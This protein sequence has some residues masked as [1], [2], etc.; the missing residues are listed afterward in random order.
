LY[1]LS[2]LRFWFSA[3]FNRSS[4]HVR[5]LDLSQDDERRWITPGILGTIPN[6]FACFYNVESLALTNVDLGLFDELSLT[7][8]FG[9]MERLTSLSIER[10]AVSPDALGFFVCM[11]P[12]LDDLKLDNLVLRSTTSPFRKPSITP[13]FRGK[14]T[15]LNLT[16]D[17]TS[18][19]APFIDPPILMAFK[20]VHVENCR[21]D[22][23]KSLK[24]L[25]VAC[26][27]TVKMVKVS[28]IYLD[29]T[30]ETPLIDLAPLKGLEEIGL[31]LIYLKQPNHWIEAILQTVTSTRVRKITF[32]TD[33]PSAAADIGSTINLNLRSWSSLDLMFLK[34][35]SR[36]SGAEEKLEV[37]FNAV[38]TDD[39]EVFNPVAV[40]RFLERCRTKATVRFERAREVVPDYF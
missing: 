21:F 37:V 4:H 26:Q 1:S 30:S 23:P 32:D 7:R 36:L 2:D 29:D 16:T 15:L 3:G 13:R 20:D 38:E 35:A 8:F 6:D 5:S 17:G 31:S 40:G 28:R 24:D 34:M 27:E 22:A 25:F 9:H 19:I 14:L 33:F 10:S 18:I 39:P 12:R 11:F